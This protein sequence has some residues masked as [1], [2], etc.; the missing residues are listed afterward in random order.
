M[1]KLIMLVAILVRQ[2]QLGGA[3]IG[4]LVG[5]RIL[6]RL[7]DNFEQNNKIIFTYRSIFDKSDGMTDISGIRFRLLDYPKGPGLDLSDKFGEL[8]VLAST[9]DIQLF[10]N[11]FTVI[12]IDGD[13]IEGEMEVEY[14]LPSGARPSF[15]TF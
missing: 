4:S 13:M 5:G 10:P 12:F 3:L 15:I 7:H 11:N 8:K 9:G 2:F 1:K 14:V 6:V